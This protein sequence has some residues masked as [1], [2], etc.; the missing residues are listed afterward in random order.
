LFFEE[1][2][3]PS[4]VL[5]PVD[6]CAFCWLAAVWAGVDMDGK[7]LKEKKRPLPMAAEAL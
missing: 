6:S 5:G 7:L 1:A 3:L 4:S 2:A